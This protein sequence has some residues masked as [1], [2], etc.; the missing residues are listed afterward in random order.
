MKS[1][2]SDVQ[3]STKQSVGIGFDPIWCLLGATCNGTLFYKGL[4]QTR[5]AIYLGCHAPRKYKDKLKETETM[6]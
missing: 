5:L 6:T 1:I 4:I 2:C 3:K